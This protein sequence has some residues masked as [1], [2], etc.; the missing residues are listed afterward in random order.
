MVAVGGIGLSNVDRLLRNADVVGVAVV[1]S[2][3]G[4]NDPKEA[5]AVLRQRINWFRRP[6]DFV[7]QQIDPEKSF[8]IIGNVKEKLA[9]VKPLIHHITNYVV[10]NDTANATIALGA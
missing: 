9:H 3:M 2:I 6:E 8:E 1:R 5:A 7:G 10:M 4:A